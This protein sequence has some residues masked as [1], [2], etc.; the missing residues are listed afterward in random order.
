MKLNND[1]VV[2]LIGVKEK[3]AANGEAIRFLLEKTKGQKVFMKFDN[4]K[5]DDGNNLLCYLYLRTK[6]L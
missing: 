6:H 3:K 1:L 2:R 5:Y 4:R